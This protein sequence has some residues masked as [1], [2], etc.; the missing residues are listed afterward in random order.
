MLGGEAREGGESIG[1]V[2]SLHDTRKE[3]FQIYLNYD[4]H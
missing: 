2:G 4:C 3:L 1:V